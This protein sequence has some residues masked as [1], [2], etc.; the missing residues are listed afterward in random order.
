L[1]GASGSPPVAE[2]RLAATVH[3]TYLVAPPAAGAPHAAV[4]GFHGYG[5]TAADHLAALRRLPGA[6]RWLLAAVQGL[7]PFYRKD[8][9]VAVSWMTSFDR[10]NAIADNTRYAAA[11][12]AELAREHPSVTRW[13]LTGFSQGVAMAYRAAAGAP[14]PIHALVALAGDVPPDVAAAGMSGFPPV[15][16]GRGTGDGWYTE[17]KTAADLRTLEA[18]GVEAE[19]CVFAG[20]HEW[21]EEILTR[22]AGFLAAKLDG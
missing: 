2:R 19:T 7:H 8:G 3:G 17:E 16:I 10:A 5:E 18:R 13:A 4:V 9:T 12:L 15:L 6:D 1:S 20:G 21:A 11:V 14:H 22:A